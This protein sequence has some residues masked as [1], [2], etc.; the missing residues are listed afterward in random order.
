MGRHAGDCQETTAERSERAAA[1]QGVPGILSHP[2]KLGSS[3]EGFYTESQ[4]EDGPAD[5][6]VID[7]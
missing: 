4:G 7:I 2:Q 1:I 3:K 5:T 6:L